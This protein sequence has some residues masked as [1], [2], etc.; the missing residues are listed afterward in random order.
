[1]LDGLKPGQRKILF[2]CF[3]RNLTK[4][5]KVSAATLDMDMHQYLPAMFSLRL[6]TEGT[7]LPSDNT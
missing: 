2:G 6:I 1:M 3:K 7:G 5:I 4:D